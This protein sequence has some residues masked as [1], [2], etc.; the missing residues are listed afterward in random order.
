LEWENFLVKS[1]ASYYFL[2]YLA[3]S[4]FLPYMS[5]YFSE[6]GFSGT[7]V[8]MILSLWA[9]VSVV[10]QPVM[11]MIN[12]RMNDPRKLLMLCAIIAPVLGLGFYYLDSL[13]PILA[14]SVV[15]TWFQASAAP[16]SDSLAISVGNKEGFSFGS[17]RLWGALSYSIGAFCT[18][19]IYE[20]I[21]YASSFFVYLAISVFVFLVVFFIPKTKPSPHKVTIFEQAREVLN[22]KPFIAFL[23]ISLLVSLCSSMNFTFLPL[24][25]K[26]M[27]FNTKWLGTAFAIAAIVEVPM[28][29]FSAKL[30]KRI[31][32]FN[33]LCFASA[34]TA[35]RFILLFAFQN[36]YL[37][38]SLQAIDGISYALFASLAVEVVEGYASEKTKATFQTIFAAVTYG[39][40]GIIGSTAG[41]ILIDYKGAPF[42]YLVLFFVSASA[43]M[44]FIAARHFL[45]KTAD[46]RITTAIHPERKLSN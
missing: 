31:G 19:F 1:L 5:I 34:L 28:F 24:Y 29:W 37:V 43:A 8:G 41:G 21:G 3:Q 20:K 44:L 6:K 7:A 15:F 27:G 2:W 9:F 33:V 32:R 10:S 26:E 16:L 45:L 46:S 13:A 40:G 4:V 25:F 39:L 23:A 38:L 18:G 22:H 17:I 42:L 14:L 36:V 30:G 11:G 35:V 12:D